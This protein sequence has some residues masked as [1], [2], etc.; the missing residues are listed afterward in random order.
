MDVK[1]GAEVNVDV[2]VDAVVDVDEV[3]RYGGGRICRSKSR[4]GRGGENKCWR[5]DANADV[6][7]DVGMQMQ[8]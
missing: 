1:A 7:V 6:D 3:R 8:T 5:R 4:L 2:C